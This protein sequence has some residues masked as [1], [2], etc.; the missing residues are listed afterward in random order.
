MESDAGLRA[1][2]GG[3][4][5]V[6]YSYS[7]SLSDDHRQGPAPKVPRDGLSEFRCPGEQGKNAG[8]SFTTK[9]LLAALLC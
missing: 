1:R 3:R 5:R 7:A 8:Y 6:C 4:C 2:Q 9:A